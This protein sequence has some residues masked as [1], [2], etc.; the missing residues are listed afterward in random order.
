MTRYIH[1]LLALVFVLV[2]VALMYSWSEQSRRTTS[3]FAGH[4]YHQRY[5][6]AA[7]MLRPPSSL[8]VDPDGTLILIDKNSNSTSIPKAKLPFMIGGHEG[9]GEH[10]F[11]MIALGPSTDGI[12]HTPAV[13]LH[14]GIVGGEISI[15][16]VED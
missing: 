3:R 15:E 10:D 1:I 2:C 7:L 8:E 5:E 9:D 11:M 16:G 12:L 4:L 6:E 14:L 13:T